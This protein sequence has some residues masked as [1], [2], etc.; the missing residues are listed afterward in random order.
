MDRLTGVVHG[1]GEE[2]AL[3][4]LLRWLHDALSGH[5]SYIYTHKLYIGRHVGMIMAHA[6][7]HTIMPVAPVECYKRVL[8]QICK[9]HYWNLVLLL[10]MSY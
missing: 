5:Y 7:H 2:T 10:A 6:C 1:E 3:Y 4:A 9:I 8:C